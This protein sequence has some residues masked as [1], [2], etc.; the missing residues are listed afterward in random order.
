MELDT[1]M[2]IILY[3]LSFEFHTNEYLAVEPPDYLP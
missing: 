3:L 1:N 2:L